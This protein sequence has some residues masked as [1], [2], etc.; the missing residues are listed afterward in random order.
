MFS[1]S[2]KLMKHISISARSP[3]YSHLSASLNGLTTIRSFGAQPILVKEFDKIQ[4]NHSSGDD[5]S[6]K[7]L[8][9][10]V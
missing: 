5:T 1:D 6:M 2:A 9:S 7:L 8:E 10:F 3:I 4:D